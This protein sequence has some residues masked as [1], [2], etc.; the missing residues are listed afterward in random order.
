MTAKSL[1]FMAIH[2]VSKLVYFTYLRDLQPTYIGLIID[3]LSTSRT[4]LSSTPSARPREVPQSET[5]SQGGRNE[6]G[7]R[8]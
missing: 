4:S 3:L 1:V 7:W 8:R 6:L 5:W 2:F